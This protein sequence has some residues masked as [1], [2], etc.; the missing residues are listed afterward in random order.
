MDPAQAAPARTPAPAPAPSPAAS[1]G[2]SL[3][4]RFLLLS[5]L[6]SGGQGAV[7]RAFDQDTGELLALKVLHTGGAEA[8]PAL[9]R[10]FRALEG[11]RHPGLVRL[12]ELFIDG[13]AAWYTME[14]LEG[15]PLI[16]HLDSP[17][18]ARRLGGV[19]Q[20]LCGALQALHAAG[21]VHRDVKPANIRL[22][23]DRRAVL[24]DPGLVVGFVDRSGVDPRA[25]SPA[26]GTPRWQAP[27]QAAGGALSPA[28]DVYALGQLWQALG[29][30]EA[31]DLPARLSD[32]LR[33]A[34]AFEA[35]DRCS[36]AELSLALDAWLGAQPTGEVAHPIE[37]LGAEPLL[38]ALDGALAAWSAQEPA[39]LG[40]VGAPGSGKT[41]L[42]S[43]WARTAHRADRLCLVIPCDPTES[44]PF[45]ALDRLI[46]RLAGALRAGDLHSEA[47]HPEALAPDDAR[48]LTQLFPVLQGALGDEPRPSRALDP[49]RARGRAVTA[50]G[51]LLHG[52]LS[53]RRVV[54]I[55]DDAQWLD[56]DSHSLLTELT[57]PPSA[58]PLLLVLGV[59]SEGIAGE[60]FPA[61][62]PTLLHLHPLSPEASLLLLRQRGVGEDLIPGVLSAAA[63]NPHLLST[64]A[65]L[66]VGGLAGWIAA[67]EARHGTLALDL[68]RTFALAGAPLDPAGLLDVLPTAGPTLRALRSQ[69]LLRESP[70]PTARGAR[71]IGLTLGHEALAA[72]LLS[73]LTAVERLALHAR[74]AHGLV[75]TE[76]ARIDLLVHHTDAAGDRE[77]ALQ[78][79]EA[80]AAQAWQAQEARQAYRFYRLV[81][82]LDPA[83]RAAAIQR[84]IAEVAASLGQAEAA[85]AAWDRV[86]AALPLDPDHQELRVL[87]R[88]GRVEQL[89]RWGDAAAGRQALEGLLQ[90]LGHR[91]PR[92]RLSLAL[93]T[94]WGRLRRLWSGMRWR[95][96]ERSAP[97]SALRALWVATLSR[98]FRD[99]LEEEYI[100]LLYVDEALR[101]AP[102]WALA[103]ALAWEAGAR[104]RNPLARLT[105]APDRLLDTARRMGDEAL[106]P[107]ERGVI[108]NYEVVLQFSR[109]N[110]EA[111]RRA[112]ERAL[113]AYR[114]AVESTYWGEFNVAV[115]ANGAL[116]YA[117]HIRAL[118]AFTHE[119]RIIER[120]HDLAGLWDDG[121]WWTALRMALLEGELGAAQTLLDAC[122]ARWARL[123]PSLGA[124]SRGLARAEL[125]V[126]KGDLEGAAACIP[127]AN[128]VVRQSGAWLIHW[129]AGTWRFQRAGI[130]LAAAHQRGA[131]EAPAA[132]LSDARWLDRCRWTPG[133][134]TAALLRAAAAALEGRPAEADGALTLARREAERHG[135]GLL[136]WWIDWARAPVEAPISSLDPEIDP[137]RLAATIL[138]LPSSLFTRAR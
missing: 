87:A 24:I 47:L 129:A 99:L 59:P 136:T 1:P 94:A 107:Y 43:A 31:A 74:I 44:I 23:E 53:S 19:L 52:Y 73:E 22:T 58:L 86:L 15:E 100:G 81:E 36:L 130:L 120:A 14:L 122:E 79:A 29:E 126:A 91:L 105:G 26:A 78:L 72:V 49:A 55:L 5:P 65:S 7:F 48:A 88:T 98:S 34:R 117:G 119:H 121:H 93:H 113:S 115:M 101:G 123:G 85:A 131:K 61:L 16:E 116:W 102:P 57:R 71:T 54:L 92:G 90:E 62:R 3:G 70:L 25:L 114:E 111:C 118:R 137:A 42:L 104:E 13:E 27:E 77:R 125:A 80:A 45:Q 75:R 110:Q 63:G 17:D 76:D 4:G 112:G 103:R 96:D 132:V 8:H 106:G 82:S 38:S 138:P 41:G 127:E 9:K 46:D 11:I 30:P 134:A 6:G 67:A 18:R 28:V 56:A 84:R 21:R 32:C 37:L 108:E 89:F 2:A 64:L 12:Y 95:A 33:R 69:G 50:L 135:A 10:E 66:G 51:G 97:A 39:L 40:L 60:L 83:W 109:G 124:W 35:R 20:Q 128:R 133:P 68:L